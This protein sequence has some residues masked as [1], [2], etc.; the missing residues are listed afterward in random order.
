MLA[1]ILAQIGGAALKAWGMAN[2][3]DHPVLSP[4][5][6]E[7]RATP[8]PDPAKNF[9]GV[10]GDTGRAMSAPVVPAA[11]AAVTTA[12]PALGGAVASGPPV[13]ASRT[14]E[15]QGG[16]PQVPASQTLEEQTQ[17]LNPKRNTFW[18]SMGNVARSM[19]P[20]NQ[21]QTTVP[22]AQGAA[23]SAKDVAKGLGKK[24][25]PFGIGNAI[26]K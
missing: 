4:I 2:K 5:G 14:L 26:W 25:L 23:T 11:Q 1:Q 22:S 3:L 9:W 18:G 12:A 8:L 24:L 21:G 20:G 19:I 7:P 13:P 10:M 17:A 15:E 16:P 6:A